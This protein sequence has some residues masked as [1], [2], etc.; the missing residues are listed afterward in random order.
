MSEKHLGCYM[1][2][3]RRQSAYLFIYLLCRYGYVL[4]L[5]C[6]RVFVL[7]LCCQFLCLSWLLTVDRAFEPV[8]RASACPLRSRVLL[9]MDVTPSMSL[10]F[11]FSCLCRITNLSSYLSLG[12]GHRGLEVDIDAVLTRMF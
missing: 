10:L 11:C 4:L 12:C 2:C 9:A 3:L 7:V 1:S 8:K 5:C 6:G